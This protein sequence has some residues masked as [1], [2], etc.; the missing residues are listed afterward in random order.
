MTET[1]L[2]RLQKHEL[3]L[4]KRCRLV[5][6][7][8]GVDI[9]RGIKFGLGEGSPDLCGV[10]TSGHAFCIET[11]VPGGRI[12]PAQ[13]AWWRAAYKWGVRGGIARSLEG[14]WRLLDEAERGPMTGELRDYE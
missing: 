6:N 14:A 2:M 1:Q 10:L 12:R 3:N 4:S 5:R 7:N 9:E 13:I 11:K 8:V